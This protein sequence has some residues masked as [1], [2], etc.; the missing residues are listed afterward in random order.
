MR[1]FEGFNPSGPP[2]PLCGT[3]GDWPTVLLPKP[4]SEHDGLVEAGQVHHACYIAYCR[5]L[6]IEVEEGET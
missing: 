3:R 5:A 6:G 4:G 1:V 2:C